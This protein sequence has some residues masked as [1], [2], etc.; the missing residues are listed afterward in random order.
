MQPGIPIAYCGPPPLPSEMVASWNL[1][2][3]V[4]AALGML[5]AGGLL[6]RSIPTYRRSA[7]VA[8]AIVLAIA[9]VS[10]LC[11]MTTALFSARAIHHI[12]L[13]AVAAPLLAM[14]F[15]FRPRF[16]TSAAFLGSTVVLWAWH[17]PALYSA[18][19]SSTVVYWVLQ[20]LL[21][22]TAWLFWSQLMDI[23]CPALSA[24]PVIALG[25]GQM[26]LLAALLTFAPDPLYAEHLTTT[27]AFG[28]SPLEDQQLAGLV[29]WVPGM[30]VFLVLALW[31]GR[32]SWFQIST[33]PA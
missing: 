20:G 6:A 5:A 14:A 33:G 23:K 3:L 4:L 26:G 10:P 16:P 22:S 19:L 9:F 11:A 15:P 27:A 18:A 31:L 12:L 7:M 17:L 1:D 24:L 2:P 8:A 13:Y 25:A 21:V 28:L 32:R 30:A 29:M